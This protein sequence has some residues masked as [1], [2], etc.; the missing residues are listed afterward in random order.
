MKAKKRLRKLPAKR[1]RT[2]GNCS[3]ND[4]VPKKPRFDDS[5]LPDFSNPRS[6]AKFIETAE[7]ILG[8][9]SSSSV[10]NSLTYTT[11]PYSAQK[12]RNINKFYSILSA[13][14]T[15]SELAKTQADPEQDNEKNV[16]TKFVLLTRGGKTQPK[17]RI[18]NTCMI[19]VAQQLRLKNASKE[20]DWSSTWID[21]KKFTKEHAMACYQPDVT[22][23][24][25]RHLFKYFHDEGIIFS[26]A[27]D[28]NF[29]GGFQA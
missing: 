13:H 11:R 7:G 27:K 1:S 20:L 15:L 25:H 19:L 16:V 21:P 12:K 10:I 24:F 4:F 18:V 8:N 28:F 2:S 6:L 22:S 23:L 9:V 17:K 26:Q 29:Q 14:P 5:K 3:D